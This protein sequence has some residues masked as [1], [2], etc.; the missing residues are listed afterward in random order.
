MA[1]NT[2]DYRTVHGIHG[3]T[4]SHFPNDFTEII[5]EAVKEAII[6]LMDTP[7]GR[8][9]FGPLMFDAVGQYIKS[10]ALDLEKHHPDGTIERVKENGDI[11]AFIAKWISQAEGAIRGVQSDAAQARNR[12]AE[13]R[14]MLAVAMSRAANR[15]IEPENRTKE[16]DR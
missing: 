14:D 4:H 8:K 11:L 15:I 5:K 10:Y 3:H 2:E 12:A 1:Q 9:A 16:I 6:E 7:E 13:T